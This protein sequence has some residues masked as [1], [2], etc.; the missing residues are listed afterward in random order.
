MLIAVAGGIVLMLVVSYGLWR[1]AQEGIGRMEE[2]L[3]NAVRLEAIKAQHVQPERNEHTKIDTIKF[4]DGKAMVQTLIAHTETSGQVIVYPKIVFYAQTPHGWQRTAP[5]GIFWGE[6]QML[7]TA[8]LHFV[9]GGWDRAAVEQ[10][11]PGA[12]SLYIALRRALGRSP[13]GADGLLTIEIVRERVLPDEA[14]IDGRMRLTS[15]RLY[16]LSF[17]YTAEELLAHFTREG[18]G[19]VDV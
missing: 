10:L 5:V 11:A 7:D 4:Q 16:D 6:T 1:A 17:G 19:H 8:H 9:F 3:A 14:V 15:P 18:Y 2:E 13:T 12:E